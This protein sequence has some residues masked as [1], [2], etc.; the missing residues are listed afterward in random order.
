[1]RRGFRLL[2]AV[3]ALDSLSRS[4]FM[5]F[6]PFLLIGKGASIARRGFSSR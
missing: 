4:G 1:M 3:G 2:L 6:V 5:V